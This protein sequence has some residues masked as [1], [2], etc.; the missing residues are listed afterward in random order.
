MTVGSAILLLLLNVTMAAPFV[1]PLTVLLAAMVCAALLPRW[2]TVTSLTY[3]PRKG[4]LS[5]SDE[6]RI[7]QYEG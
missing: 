2:M 7:E 3:A 4:P 5:P 1:W 6:A